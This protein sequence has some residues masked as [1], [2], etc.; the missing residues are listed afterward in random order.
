[1]RDGNFRKFRCE[2]LFLSC[3][4]H[5]RIWVWEGIVSHGWVSGSLK[6][7]WEER[8]KQGCKTKGVI[9]QPQKTMWMV[10]LQSCKKGQAIT[11]LVQT[12]CGSLRDPYLPS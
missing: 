5:I 12:A 7:G 2:Y 1:M 8:C 10:K 3:L 9:P 4:T 6:R 11:G